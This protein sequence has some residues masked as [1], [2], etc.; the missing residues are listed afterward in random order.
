MTGPAN[1]GYRA[2]IDADGVLTV[3]RVPIFV[4]CQRGE[5]KADADW[6][7]AA[8]AHATQASS[9]GYDP[10]LHIRHH[11]A[12]AEVRPAGFFRILGAEPII[13]KGTPRLAILADLIITDP[14]ARGEV[15]SSRLPYR[16]VEIYDIDKPA[17]DSLA[18]LDHEAP[19][20]ELPM[21]MVSDVRDLSTQNAFARVR[22]PWANSPTHSEP[23]VACFRR[24]RS[25][26]LLIE[27]DEPMTQ[28]K[29]EPAEQFGEGVD[30]AT[31]DVALADGPPEKG[32]DKKK[33]DDGEQMAD[34]PGMDVKAICKAITDGSIS[35]ADM[36]EI[37]AAIQARGGA[38]EPEEDEEVA[39]PAA[40]P[41]SMSKGE[42][43][44]LGRVQALEA[45]HAEAKATEQRQ[46][47][48]DEAMTRLEGRPLGSDPRD[49]FQA[50]HK[51][52][53]AEAFKLF[54]DEMAATFGRAK[55]DSDVETFAKVAS[56]TP[57]VAM[58]YAEKGAEAVER[59]THFAR[60][61]AEL[62]KQPGFRMSLDRY[63][64][65]QMGR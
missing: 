34:D 24:G 8:V 37:M 41:E 28:T 7:R 65:L 29:T 56:D 52:H 43:K 16:S 53:G 21:L 19:Y 55:S 42:A 46:R 44:L 14:A 60:E 9:E 13:F 35:V 5:F 25:A 10:P 2:T 32:D 38:V 30:N 23:V 64:E 33:D 40:A 22:N 48:V 1:I 58:K 45:I 50:F 20:L 49:R 31:P 36:E 57:E 11:E 59:A 6:I 17:I 63:V 51:Q 62:S 3:H 47:D 27:G 18:L 15:L 12:G 4:E 26:H 61:H 54:V 39:A